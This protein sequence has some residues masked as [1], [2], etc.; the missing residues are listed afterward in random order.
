[1]SG[2]TAQ[3]LVC[4]AELFTSNAAMLPVA[5][6]QGRA[7]MRQLARNWAIAY[8][9]ELAGFPGALLDL[10]GASLLQLGTLQTMS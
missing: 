5:I 3:V 7:T 8:S 9:G 6:Y 1:M 2:Q 10:A 4:G